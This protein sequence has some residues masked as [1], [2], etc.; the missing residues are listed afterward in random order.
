M[1]LFDSLLGKKKNDSLNNDNNTAY[2]E[3]FS[4]IADRDEEVCGQINELIDNHRLFVTKHEEMFEEMGINPQ[5][6]G[7]FTVKWAGCTALLTDAGYAAEVDHNVDFDDFYAAL[8]QLKKAAGRNI[9]PAEDDIYLD[10]DI[11]HWLRAIDSAWAKSG[12]CVGGIDKNSDS[13]VLFICTVE[14]LA[15]LDKLAEGAGR[16]IKRACEL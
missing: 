2:K 7:E 14:E 10:Y 8:G 6:A 9:L 1:G 11:T 12:L 4:L 5:T 15:K 13:Y 16:K 3:I